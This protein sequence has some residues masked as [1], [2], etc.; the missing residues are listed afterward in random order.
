MNQYYTQLRPFMRNTHS[1]AHLHP[2]WTDLDV[3]QNDGK[4]PRKQAANHAW[5][6]DLRYM[7]LI[8]YLSSWRAVVA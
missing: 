6:D 1:N 7:K 5:L 2:I 3:L 4:N 8:N